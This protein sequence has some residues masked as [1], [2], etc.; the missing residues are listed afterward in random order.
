MKNSNLLLELFLIIILGF[1][2]SC[3]NNN[4]K[5]GNYS[6]DLSAES[7]SVITNEIMDLTTN[8][9]DANKNM[10]AD[11]AIELWDS[12]TELMFAENGMFFPNRDSLYAYLKGFYASTTSMDL[13]WQK[14]VVVPLSLNAASMSGYFH[15]KAIFKTGDIF[16]GNSM[17]TGVFVRKNNKWILI[18]GHESV[19]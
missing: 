18:H 19:K 8:W 5:I 14:R 6:D 7:K 13:Q 2:Q 15:F 17:F 3:V 4:Q 11:K 9:A 10:D 12:S 16:E 1:S